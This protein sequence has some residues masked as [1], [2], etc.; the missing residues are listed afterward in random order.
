MY[1]IYNTADGSLVARTDGVEYLGYEYSTRSYVARSF[2]DCN[3][4]RF[5]AGDTPVT[6]NLI[7]H[8][9]LPWLTMTVKVLSEPDEEVVPVDEL[10]QPEEVVP[11]DD[12]PPEPEDE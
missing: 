11:V 7:G 12:L 3:A 10:P 2:A 5:M 8:E 9:P 1:A 4:V 6:A